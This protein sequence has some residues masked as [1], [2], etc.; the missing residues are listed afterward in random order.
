MIATSDI[1]LS[2]FRQ[3]DL[4]FVPGMVVKYGDLYNFYA[5]CKNNG[6]GV[7]SIAPTGWH[8]PNDAEWQT[9]ID[10]LGG[11]NFAGGH[12]KKEGVVYWET[13]QADNSS[14]F[15]ALGAGFRYH[16]IGFT[17]ILQ[18]AH[19][20]SSTEMNSTYSDY[21]YMISGDKSCYLSLPNTEPGNLI[22]FMKD[23]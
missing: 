10:E 18:T 7:G 3:K 23:N 20:W 21:V 15:S 11:V 4:P 1:L 9:L 2:R 6:S 16:D 12:L 19:F 14:K 8:L 13:D 17:N 5:A 22:R